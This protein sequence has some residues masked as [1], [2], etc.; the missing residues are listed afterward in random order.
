[1]GFWFSM[2]FT[3]FATAASVVNSK[4]SFLLIAVKI[5]YHDQKILERPRYGK[6]ILV[7][8]GASYSGIRS[9]IRKRSCS[10]S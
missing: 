3:I 5:H 10:R 2:A 1:M 9:S 8:F 6:V 4:G 7:A